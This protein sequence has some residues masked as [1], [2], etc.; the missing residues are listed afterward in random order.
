[1][2][3]VKNVWVTLRVVGRDV[4][5]VMLC[6]VYYVDYGGDDVAGSVLE[7]IVNVVRAEN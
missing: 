7:L 1:M 6:C 2:A 4:A 3:G 5:R